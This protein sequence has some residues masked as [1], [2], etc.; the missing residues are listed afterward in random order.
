[1][2]NRSSQ[3]RPVCRSFARGVIAA[4]AYTVLLL[5]APTGPAPGQLCV[6][7]PFDTLEI[8]I[9]YTTGIL[10]NEYTDFWKTGRGVESWVLTPFYAGELKLAARYLFHPGKTDTIPDY[11][12][13]FACVG[14]SYSL[15]LH[16][17]IVIRPGASLGGSVMRFDAGG[18]VE[19]KT[20]SEIST[21]LFALMALRIHGRWH[22]TVCSGWT[23]MLTYRR[24]D[25]AYVA[26]G[27]SGSLGM[28][29]W[30]RGFLE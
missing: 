5:A 15:R 27:V 4:S 8:G 19:N 11:H 30:L 14:W 21:D 9:Q 12:D 22:V 2:R 23:R 7:A 10:E 17:R 24:I 6:A 13:V 26:V 16:H 25:S 1:M 18:S 28:P 20:E 29:R 3:N